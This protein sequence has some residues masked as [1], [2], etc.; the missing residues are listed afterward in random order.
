[1]NQVK[2][3]DSNIMQIKNKIKSFFCEPNSNTADA[4]EPFPLVQWPSVLK[5]LYVRGLLKLFLACVFIWIENTDGWN[6]VLM[7]YA[8]LLLGSCHHDDSSGPSV[9]LSQLQ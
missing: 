6:T 4:L 2:T 8:L 5:V 1:M 3:C 9:S 7:F